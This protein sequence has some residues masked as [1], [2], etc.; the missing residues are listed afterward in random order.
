MPIIIFFSF[1]FSIFV[2]ASPVTATPPSYGEGKATQNKIQYCN[3]LINRYGH[4]SYQINDDYYGI[5][6]SRPVKQKW[7]L[8][9]NEP[10]WFS[11]KLYVIFEQTTKEKYE[12]YTHRAF[13]KWEKDGNWFEFVIGHHSRQGPVICYKYA[14]D[15]EHICP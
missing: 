10:G 9:I 13:C 1:V 15:R 5:G 11:K 12:D 6:V 2:I 8:Q 14:T 7:K 4:L 3:K